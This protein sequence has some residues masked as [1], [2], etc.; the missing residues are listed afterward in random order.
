MKEKNRRASLKSKGIT[1]L[2][3][4][5]AA[6]LLG[7]SEQYVRSRCAS[8]ELIATIVGG[9]WHIEEKA[10]ENFLKGK[11]K[12]KDVRASELAKENEAIKALLKDKSKNAAVVGREIQRK[13]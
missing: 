4:S 1:Y 11:I 5:K 10:L 3:V 9:A 6:S 8:G 2:H 13:R 12:S 7:C